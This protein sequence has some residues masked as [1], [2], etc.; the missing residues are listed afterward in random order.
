V[1][2]RITTQEPEASSLTA[3]PLR[4]ARIVDTGTLRRFAGSTSVVL[5]D[6]ARIGRHRLWD[7]LLAYTPQKPL[8]LAHGE[9]LADNVLYTRGTVGLYL[10]QAT[11]DTP[12]TRQMVDRLRP[13]LARF[14][15]INVRAVVILAPRLDI[16]YVYGRGVVIGE[17][18]QDSHPTIEFFTGLGENATAPRPSF[19]WGVL[20]ANIVDQVSAD[21]TNLTSL[22]RRAHFSDPL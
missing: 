17:A 10:S 3:T 4:S 13:V 22:R 14:L 7:D 6:A 1:E 16:E 19:N 15:P 18:Y 2:T 21:P 5:R 11:P 9:V 8:R 12:L 20:H